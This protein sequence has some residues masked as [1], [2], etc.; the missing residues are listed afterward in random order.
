MPHIITIA[1][2]KG[3]VGKT[4]TTRHLAECLTNQNLRVLVIDNDHQGNLT[5]Y[6]GLNP[7]KLDA[8]TGTLYHAI[9]EKRPLREVMVELGENLAIVPSA[10]SLAEAGARLIT[11]TDVNGV[12]RD[13]LQPIL[14]DYDVVLIDCGPNLERL[15]INALVASASKPPATPAVS[16]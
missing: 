4:T 2:Q 1:N 11:E 14:S 13:A 9:I 3:G 10:L 6:F 16:T 5:T 7:V 15:L 8:T 12:L